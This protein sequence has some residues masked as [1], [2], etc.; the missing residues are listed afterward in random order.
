M[1]C[2]STTHLVDDIAHVSTDRRCSRP[3]FDLPGF[4]IDLEPRQNMQP[5]ERSFSGRGRTSRPPSQPAPSNSGGQIHVLDCEVC[6]LQECRSPGQVPLNPGTVPH[7]NST[8]AGRAPRQHARRA[9]SA[10]LDGRLSATHRH[11]AAPPFIME[12]GDRGRC[13]RALPVLSP[14]I[15]PHL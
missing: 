10:F 5:L 9:A 7:R 14:L 13:P 15:Q 4:G 1:I 6:Q 12:G 2:P 11:G 8:S 3:T